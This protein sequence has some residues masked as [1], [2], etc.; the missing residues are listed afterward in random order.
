MNGRKSD[1]KQ[2]HADFYEAAHEARRKFTEL[3]WEGR[4]QNSDEA[5]GDR[6]DCAQSIDRSAAALAMNL[7]LMEQHFEELMTLL[8]AEPTGGA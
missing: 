3:W 7:N 1:A 2:L 5:V 4:E 6:A 8:D